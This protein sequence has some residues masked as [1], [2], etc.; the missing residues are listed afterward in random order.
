MAHQTPP[1]PGEGYYVP[2]HTTDHPYQYAQRQPGP[3]ES[4]N[5]ADGL[6]VVPY[7]K[8]KDTQCWPEVRQEEVGKEVTPDTALA[9]Y[10]KWKD[11]RDQY[12]AG[13]APEVA[14][15]QPSAK[16]SRKRLCVMLGSVLAA[17]LIVAAIVGGVVGS[18]VTRELKANT[19]PVLD[20]GGHGGSS[21]TIPTPSQTTTGGG[22]VSTTA[23]ANA[24]AIRSGS[25]FAVASW[26][27]D[28]GN[29][30]LYL[31]YQDKSNDV[32]YIKHDGATW[33]KP[34]N[35]ITGLRRNTRLTATIILNGF[36][37]PARPHVILTYIGAG[38]TVLGMAIN[39]NNNPAVSDDPNIK[40]MSLEAMA[41]SSTASYYP[42]TV[43]QAASGELG[44]ALIF[45]LQW[46][47]RMTGIMA[48][49]GTSLAMVPI[50]TRWAN[51]S[52]SGGYGLIYQKPDGR[53][54]AAVP[55]LGPDART[56]AVSPWFNSSIFPS[57]ITPPN[58]AP[59]A[60]WITSR[61]SS[62]SHFPNTYIFYLDSDS[63]IQM[64]YTSFSGSGDGSPSWKTSAPEALKG[65][66]KNTEIGCVLM[67]SIDKD[68][69]GNEIPIEEDSE[70]VNR[71]FF[72]KGGKLVE[73]RMS[74]SAGTGEWKIVGEVPLPL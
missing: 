5:W 29:V 12:N 7:E 74:E 58:G 27:N 41:N 57:D 21:T 42:A 62:P 28:K 22:A 33:G 73:A 31:F 26:R 24:G 13:R 18:K 23:A 66:D 61:P 15:T 6:E 56:D 55:N 11:E 14:D 60:A 63:N 59:I 44:Q 16:P 9:N 30:A 48:L 17:I 45:M 37:N 67:A 71:C 69:N 52:T 72:Q 50:S 32:Y 43:Y 47:N 40:K 64:V 54:A 25:P 46:L 53:M 4:P 1:P 35:I 34:V 51:Y 39:E 70:E 2:S 38:S 19:N 20:S 3:D 68:Q 65:L 36:G 8:L 49:P 10:W